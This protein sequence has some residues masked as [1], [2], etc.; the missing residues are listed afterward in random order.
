MAAPRA[1][2]APCPPRPAA[3]FLLPLPQMEAR[4]ARVAGIDMRWIEHGRGLPVVLV[5]GIPTSPALWRKVAPRLDGC[6]VLAWEMVGYGASIPEGEGRDLSLRRQASHLRA[7]LAAIGVDRAVLV[8]HDLGGG[9]V[10][11]AAVA[12]PSLCA[13][14][15]LANAVG[16]DSWPVAPVRIARALGW[17][18]E[19]LPVRLLELGQIGRAHV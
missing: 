9:V 11:I 5:H 8:G 19:R 6:R 3:R 7:W 16:Y 10:Q 14:I 17:M 2:T 1:L 12:D 13:G 18:V 4:M 15:V